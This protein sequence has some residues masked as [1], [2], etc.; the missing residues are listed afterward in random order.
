[1]P[2]ASAYSRPRRCTMQFADC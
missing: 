2:N 1:V